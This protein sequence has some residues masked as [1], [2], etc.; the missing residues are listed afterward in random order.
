MLHVLALNNE[1]GCANLG[2]AYPWEKRRSVIVHSRRL[3][4]DAPEVSSRS[5]RFENSSLWR[6]T[7]IEPRS[8][9]TPTEC[10]EPCDRIRLDQKLHMTLRKVMYNMR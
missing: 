1:V 8:L 4:V 10:R 6:L 3:G 2:T 7:A 9:S 5:I